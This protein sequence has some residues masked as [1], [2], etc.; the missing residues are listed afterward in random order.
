MRSRSGLLTTFVGMV[1]GYRAGRR[2]SSRRRY[3]KQAEVLKNLHD[4]LLILRDQCLVFSVPVEPG[5]TRL[6]QVRALEPGIEEIRAYFRTHQVHLEPRIRVQVGYV[7]GAFLQLFLE[8]RAALEAEAS[9]LPAEGAYGEDFAR[10][11]MEGRREGE[12]VQVLE[13]LEVEIRNLLGPKRL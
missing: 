7:V 2:R 1:L 9:Y 11:E 3:Q 4:R 13:G 8:M 5:T 6:E 10:P 12:L